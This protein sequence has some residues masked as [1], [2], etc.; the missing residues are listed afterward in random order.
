MAVGVRPEKF[1]MSV[2]DKELPAGVNRV[3]GVVA[4]ASY[5]GVSTQYIVE[6]A[7]GHRVTV[8]EQNVERA[9][10]AELWASGEAVVLSW[11]PEHCFVVDDDGSAAAAAAD[12]LELAS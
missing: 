10:K 11:L 9:T 4:V 6:L 3:S 1:R 7:D 12:P 2:P 8:Y 5:L